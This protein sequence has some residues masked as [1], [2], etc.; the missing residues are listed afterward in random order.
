MARADRRGS[1]AAGSHFA[2]DEFDD[3]PVPGYAV[4]PVP[5]GVRGQAP[6]Q[7]RRGRGTTI[8]AV[9][10]MIVGVALLA[11]A[12]GM[13]LTSQHNYQVGKDEYAALAANVTE[14]A[15]TSEPIVDFATL[16]AT[17]PE[18]VGWVQIPGTP[19]NYPVAQHADNDYYLEHTFTG[20]YNLAGSVFMDYRSHADLSDRTTVVYGHH[21]KNGEMFA[22]VADYSDQ[23]QF[24]T[25][26]DVYYVT[27]DGQVH[28]LSALCCM[29][30]DG[31]D[32]DA[33]RTDFADDADFASYVQS[34]VDRSSARA[35]GASSAGVGHVYLLS[36]CSYERQNDRT[37]LVCVDKSATGGAATDATADL[38]DIQQAA[39]VAAEE[40][41]QVAGEGDGEDAAA[42]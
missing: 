9:I 7:S 42:A 8:A 14:D 20:Q 6:A 5:A 28:V 24:D 22:K 31:G 39:G 32:V 34:L 16:K 37:I 10:L 23:A 13:Y 18:V 17:N 33:V 2:A 36:T 11:V 19:V 4:P 25:L 15:A 1:G 3:A 12:L 27:D 35:A 26:G 41:Q 38:Q 21:L 40:A 30:V 29:V